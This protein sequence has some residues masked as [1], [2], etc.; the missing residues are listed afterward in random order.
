MAS[1]PLGGPQK[2]AGMALIEILV[3]LSILMLMAVT[4]YP[5]LDHWRFKVQ[6]ELD[7]NRVIQLMQWARNRALTTSSCYQLCI[8]GDEPCQGP[9]SQINWQDC[10][11]NRIQT[12]D[13]KAGQVRWRGFL[14]EKGLGFNRL[15]QPL[16]IT[17]SLY[18][19]ADAQISHRL[20]VN[21]S[22]RVRRADAD[23]LNTHLSADYC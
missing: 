4:T 2:T 8:L 5:R 23:E 9:G 1:R 15:G 13:L 17:G 18:L 12:F 19:C 6:L 22:G 16:S 7:Y 3:S 20:I 21:R 11:G 10:A 14:S